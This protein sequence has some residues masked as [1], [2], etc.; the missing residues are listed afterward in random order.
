MTR[1][2]KEENN[3]ERKRARKDTIEREDKVRGR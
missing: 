1:A 2:K 3:K